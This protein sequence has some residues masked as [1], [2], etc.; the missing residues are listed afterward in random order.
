MNFQTINKQRKFM[1][2][3]SALGII[4]MFLP[5]VRISFLG[6]VS[7]SINGMRDWGILAFICF[8]IA[9][10]IAYSGKQDKPLDQMPW[11]IAL[12]ASA[13]ATIIMAVFFFKSSE[14]RSFLSFG[15]YGAL[16]S[17]A[18]LLFVTYAFRSAGYNIKDGFDQ[19]KKQVGEKNPQD[20]DNIS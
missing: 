18:G 14:V 1:L 2:I 13:V 6:I 4:C 20:P 3:L 8:L 5:W 9:G 15:F 7:H 19:I 16:I 10:F 17:A 11:T 12:I